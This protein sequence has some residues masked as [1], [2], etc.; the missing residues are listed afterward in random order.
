MR[1][2][3]DKK[4]LILAI[5]FGVLGIHRLYMRSWS[6]VAYIPALLTGVTLTA[7]PLI[8]ASSIGW[9]LV[10]L[11]TIFYMSDCYRIY[12]G[13][14]N[15]NVHEGHG[16]TKFIILGLFYALVLW[17]LLGL[18]IIFTRVIQFPSDPIKLSKSMVSDTD[19]LTKKRL[20][21]P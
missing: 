19:N 8:I 7:S 18:L 14:L 21:L 17:F 5:V 9:C 1:T 13:K 11:V 16:R 4:S 12:T 3:I 20:S 15:S 10:A 2:H 6:G